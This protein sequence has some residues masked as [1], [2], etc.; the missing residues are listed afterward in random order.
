[1]LTVHDYSPCTLKT[2]DA[3]SSVRETFFYGIL[4]L[5]GCLFL[6]SGCEE[7]PQTSS[8]TFD[9]PL[10]RWGSV[11][12]R[13]IT[14]RGSENDLGRP[15]M[16]KAFERYQDFTGN[17]IHL[18]MFTH[19]E[20]SRTLPTVFRGDIS[21]QPDILHGPGGTSLGRLDPDSH[22]YDFTDA[23]W[24]NDLTDTAINQTIWNGK[25]IGLPYGEA[26]VSGMLYNKEL[27]KKYSLTV[28]RTQ[29]E[30]LD[31][32]ERLL[33]NGITPVYLPY[34]ER[35]MLL[36]QFPM[37]SILS[38]TRKL[39]AL[40]NGELSYAQIPEMKEIVSWYKTM[41]DRGYFGEKYLEN[42]WDGMDEAMRSEKYAM[43]ICWDTWL[44]TNFTGNPSRF[45]LMP[46]FMGVPEKGSFEG[47]NLMLLAVNKNSPQLD[48]A[49]DLI[50]FMADPYNY[51]MSL[52]GMYTT[53]IFR[54]QAGTI[55][56]P[57]YVESER[58]IEKLLYDSTAWLRVWGFSQ[59]DAGYVQKHMQDTSYSVEECL[60]DMDAARI[61]RAENKD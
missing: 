2:R 60:K 42:G 6:L 46:A 53:P 12:G 22:F 24:V 35:T 1:M 23:Q 14:I 40:N 5:L 54:N 28:P 30:F 21:E 19:Q 17:T 29:K 20:L 47:P 11:R 7:S 37:D 9:R 56:T 34:S 55:A 44:Y 4:F 26:S 3:I 15:Y 13:T 48:A 32:C 33:K 43:M 27:F 25:V 50:Q 8:V 59:L 51:N 18:Q 39:D 38:D 52:S 58:L 57:Q 61:Q 10:Y 45:G 31:V 36:Y 16:L 49:L 41:S